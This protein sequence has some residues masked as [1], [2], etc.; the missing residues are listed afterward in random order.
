MSDDLDQL[1]KKVKD[2]DDYKQRMRQLEEALRSAGIPMPPPAEAA[3]VA[4]LH[5]SQPGGKRAGNSVAVSPGLVPQQDSTG[6]AAPK[7]GSGAEGEL[8]DE[9]G[10]DDPCPRF[11]C[12]GDHCELRI[13]VVSPYDRKKQLQARCGRPLPCSSA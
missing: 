9:A 5:N 2:V 6:F 7:K 13:E 3:A 1:G 10:C 8:D 12:R 4:V 11:S